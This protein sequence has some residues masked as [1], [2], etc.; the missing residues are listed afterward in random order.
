LAY[1]LDGELNGELR[2]L[3]LDKQTTAQLWQQWSQRSISASSQHKTE[4]HSPL[5]ASSLS[6]TADRGRITV[7]PVVVKGEDFAATLQGHW[8]LAQPDKQLIQ[9]QATQGCKVLSRDWRGDQQQ[10]SLSPCDGNSI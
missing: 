8:D 2:Q 5:T 6:V 4:E 7:E 9:L 10:L 3:Q 1:S